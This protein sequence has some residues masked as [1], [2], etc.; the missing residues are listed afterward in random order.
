M[1]V[2]ELRPCK[3]DHTARAVELH[4]AAAE[5]DHGVAKTEVFALEVCDVSEHFCFRMMG[6]EDGVGEVRSGPGKRGGDRG[7]P[8]EGR[9][10]T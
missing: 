4:C 7:L 3:R 1:Y 9:A 8:S 2:A 6:V 10:E 5:G